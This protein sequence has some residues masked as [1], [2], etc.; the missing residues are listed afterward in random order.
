MEKGGRGLGEAQR[1]RWRGAEEAWEEHKE[2][3]GEERNRLGKSTKSA[4]E[5]GGRGLGRAQRA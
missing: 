2:R 5:R 1:A 4:M 3:D